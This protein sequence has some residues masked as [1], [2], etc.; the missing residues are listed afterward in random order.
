MTYELGLGS[1]FEADLAVSVNLEASVE[2]S[3]RNLIAK[4]VWVS[5]TNRLGSEVEV[6]W[7]MVLHRL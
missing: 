5:L 1:S 3:V 4:F 6:S 7:F 2:H